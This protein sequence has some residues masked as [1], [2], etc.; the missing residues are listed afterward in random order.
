M[1]KKKNPQ[2]ENPPAQQEQE[3][4]TEQQEETPAEEST[5]EEQPQEQEPQEQDPQEEPEEEEPEEEE[6]DP[7]NPQEEPEENPSQEQPPA[8]VPASDETAQLRAQLLQAQGRLAAYGAGVIPAMVDDAVTLAMAEAAKAG[9][10]TEASVTTA[11]DAVLKRHPEWKAEQKKTAGG[12][13]IG[14]DRDSGS[15]PKKPGA[16]QNTKRWNRYK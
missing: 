16:T 14:A 8:E 2:Q 6:E 3:P 7:Q 1:A 9:T 11:M 12:F 4:E 13:R 5:Q 15:T 10:V